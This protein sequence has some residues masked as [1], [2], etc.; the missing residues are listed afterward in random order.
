MMFGTKRRTGR[1]YQT[2]SKTAF[3]CLPGAPILPAVLTDPPPR[4]VR[5]ARQFAASEK[6]H[7]L[8]LPPGPPLQTE[9]VRLEQALAAESTDA[10]KHACSAILELLSDHYKIGAPKLMVLGSRPHEVHEGRVSSELFGDYSFSTARIRVWMRTAV[11]GRVTSYRGFLNTLLHEY[12]HHLDVKGL[13]FEDTPHTRGFYGR[14]DDLYHV[15]LATPAHKRP[16]LFWRKTGTVW[17][18][19]WQRIRAWRPPTPSAPAPSLWPSE[20]ASSTL[21]E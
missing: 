4:I 11:K 3:P 12:C 20:T 21:I 2:R 8:S 1:A 15:A 13:G 17:R 18:I 19:D 6:A 10:V 7:R 16:P 9:S 5:L 14:V